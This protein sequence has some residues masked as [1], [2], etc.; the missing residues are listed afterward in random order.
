M[1]TVSNLTKNYG[2]KAAVKNINLAVKKGELFAYLGP[3][4]SGKSTTIKMLMGLLEPTEG[5]VEISGEPMHLNN[6]ELKRKISFVPDTPD[7]IGK[8]T[9]NEYLN[10][11]A[12]IYKMDKQIYKEKRD[13]LV[14]M[15]ELQNDL[16]TLVEEYSHGMRQKLVVIGSLMHSPEVIFLDEPNVGL[17]PKSNRKLKDYLTEYVKEGNTVFLTTHTLSLAEDIADRI[18]IIYQGEIKALGTLQE[19]RE[20]AGSGKTLEDIF[21]ML[22]DGEDAHV[23]E[24]TES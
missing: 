21:L 8:L 17:D 4:G 10:F 12:S 9:G 18:C 16:G 14:K 3:N 13:E 7:I 20:Q 15:F 24:H 22:T 6:T 1:I 5:T 19:L 23:Q 2:S 11:V